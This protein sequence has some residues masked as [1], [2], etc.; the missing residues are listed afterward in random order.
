[1]EKHSLAIPKKE[2]EDKSMIPID[3]EL[4]EVNLDVLDVIESF[5]PFGEG[6]R[7][8]KLRTK[9]VI[10]PEREFSGGLHFSCKAQ[11][12]KGVEI[13]AMFFH[14]KNKAEFLEKIGENKE[15]SILFDINKSYFAKTNTYN[16]EI[17]CQHKGLKI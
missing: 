12:K 1:M 11:T 5:G 4:E 15:V 13:K 10:T 2:F 17:F 14:I 9:A 16:C 6:N 8:P 3:C 7:Q